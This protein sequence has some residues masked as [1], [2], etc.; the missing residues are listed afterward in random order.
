MT[1]R[2]ESEIRVRAARAWLR[3]GF[4]TPAKVDQLRRMVTPSRG[5][6][7]A[8]QLIECMRTQWKKRSEWMT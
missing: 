3:D 4:T 2:D 1:L 8:D 7:Y 6:D 5:R